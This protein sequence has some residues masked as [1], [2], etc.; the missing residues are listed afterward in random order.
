MR[1]VVSE[2]G[3]ALSSAGR[4]G[5]GL[6]RGSDGLLEKAKEVWLGLGGVGFNP[7]K[8][9]RTIL[10]VHWVRWAG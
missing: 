3:R 2:Q 7:L 9:T 5:P 4:L 10:S 6:G 1:D 8:K